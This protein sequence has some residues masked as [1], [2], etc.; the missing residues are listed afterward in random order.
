MLAQIRDM[1][2]RTLGISLPKLIKVLT[3]YIV[4]WRGYFS[5]CQTPVCSRT[6]KR[7]FAEDYACIFG[8]SGKTGKTASWNCAA[9]AY[10]NSRQRSRPVR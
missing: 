1:T 2:R 5:F 8:G 4:G 10:P 6:S 7:G 3:P 9:V